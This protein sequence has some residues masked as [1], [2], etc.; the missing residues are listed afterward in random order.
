MNGVNFVLVDFVSVN[1]LIK[2]LGRKGPKITNKIIY[3]KILQD[4]QQVHARIF[5][6]FYN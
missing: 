1:T 5:R 2:D 6:I 4:L 3:C